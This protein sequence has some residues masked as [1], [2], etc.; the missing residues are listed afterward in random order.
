MTFDEAREHAR[1]QFSRG[2]ITAARLRRKFSDISRHE[3]KALEAA[4]KKA[5][6]D[7]AAYREKKEREAARFAV[8]R[9]LRKSLLRE[10]RA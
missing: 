4:A 2:E 8:G 7:L 1:Q 6:A 3:G 9:A 5:C 10:E